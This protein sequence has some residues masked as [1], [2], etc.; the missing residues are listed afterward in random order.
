MIIEIEGR[1]YRVIAATNVQDDSETLEFRSSVVAEEIG[2]LVA[3]VTCYD[4]HESPMLIHIP[5]E[6][7]ESLAIAILA[8]SRDWFT[9]NMP[10]TKVV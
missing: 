4:R 1:N 5:H 2:D 6:I 10:H 3:G 8:F 9:K 7:E